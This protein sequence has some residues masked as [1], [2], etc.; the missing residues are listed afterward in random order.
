[1]CWQGYRPE[2]YHALDRDWAGRGAQTDFVIETLLAACGDPV[3]YR[4]A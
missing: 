2:E 3:E 4:D 1:L